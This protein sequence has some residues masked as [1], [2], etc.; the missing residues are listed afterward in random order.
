[1]KRMKGGSNVYY[2]PITINDYNLFYEGQPLP[3]TIRGISF[4]LS[5]EIAG[6]AGVKHNGLF[7]TVFSE[8]KDGI[9]VPQITVWRATMI[10]MDMIK[11]FKCDLYAIPNPE[12]E[13]AP[14]FLDRLGFKDVGGIH[15]RSAP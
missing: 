5:N 9:I 8:I 4:F 6:I 14:L 13:R 7:F 1:M 12:I 11:D 3:K 15:K 2:R 10:V